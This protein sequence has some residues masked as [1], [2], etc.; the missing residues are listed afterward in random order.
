[1]PAT[2]P[3][4]SAAVG[5][6]CRQ[7]S[8]PDGSAFEDE[9]IDWRR[10]DCGAADPASDLGGEPRTAEMTANA[11]HL[12]DNVDVETP[13]NPRARNTS[14]SVRDSM[15]TRGLLGCESPPRACSDPL[16][17][18]PRRTPERTGRPNPEGRRALLRTE[19]Q[20]HAPARSRTGAPGSSAVGQEHS[21]RWRGSRAAGGPGRHRRTMGSAGGVRDRPGFGGTF[22]VPGGRWQAPALRP[23]ASRTTSSARDPARAV[24]VHSRGSVISL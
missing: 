15:G 20:A 3:V 19:R 4:D 6:V 22:T 7:G 12:L 10:R 9:T 14:E 13:S 21:A 18:A 2:H 11:I 5:S 23:R 16:R 17:S 24:S 8:A 1:M